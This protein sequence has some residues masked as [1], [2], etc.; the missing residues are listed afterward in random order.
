MELPTCLITKV[1]CISTLLSKQIFTQ[2]IYLSRSTPFLASRDVWLWV[3][4]LFAGSNASHRNESVFVFHS[5]VSD[6]NRLPRD[7]AILSRGPSNPEVG[8]LAELSGGMSEEEQID[9]A[10]WESQQQGNCLR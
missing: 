2:L 3:M 9:R 6:V 10:L 8:R 4:K 7:D 5:S 1:A